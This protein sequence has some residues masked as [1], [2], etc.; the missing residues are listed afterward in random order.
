MHSS[1]DGYLE[2]FHL[3]AIVNSAARNLGVQIS[4]Q[5]SAL[6]SYGY[7]HISESV[8]SYDCS[9][10]NFLRDHHTVFYSDYTI[11]HSHQQCAKIS[12]FSPSASTLVIHLL[13]CFVFVLPVAILTGVR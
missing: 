3:L 2:C 11:F 13:F 10:L 7:M 6:N 8:K 1:V 4:L 12:D 5:D 9:T